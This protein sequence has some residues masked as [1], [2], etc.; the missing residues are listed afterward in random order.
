MWKEAVAARVKTPLDRRVVGTGVRVA[1]GNPPA[2]M[3]A[4]SRRALSGGL[5][6]AD[7]WAGVEFGANRNKV[8]TY[9]MRTPAG[10]RTVRRHTARQLPARNKSGRVAFAAL[11]EV[12]PRMASLMAATVVRTV[13][14]E[15]EKRSGR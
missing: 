15:V 11:K 13:M 3:A 6:P 9:S 14:D 4:T 7:E 12:A 10:T 8:T 2:A 5:V 1:G